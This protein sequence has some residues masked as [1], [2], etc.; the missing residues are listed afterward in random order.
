MI[1][2]MAIKMKVYNKASFEAKKQPKP[3][4]SISTTGLFTFNQ[5][6]A[7]LM[8]FKDGT[9]IEFLQDEVRTKDFFVRS[10]A[11]GGFKLRAK[12]SKKEKTGHLLFNSREMATVIFQFTGH[13]KKAKFRIGIS[14]DI[15]GKDT[16]PIITAAPVLKDY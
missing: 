6:A 10:T 2:T 1:Q 12:E 8:A 4:V 5:E 7:K 9:M 16:F 11:S 13:A 14:E 15:D 3:V